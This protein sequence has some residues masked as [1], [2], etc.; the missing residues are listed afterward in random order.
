MGMG[1]KKGLF[2]SVLGLLLLSGMTFAANI[3]N[4]KQ[5][6]ILMAARSAD[7]SEYCY[8][9]GV[10][11]EDKPALDPR[12]ASLR[13]AKCRLGSVM[14]MGHRIAFMCT[15]N[16]ADYISSQ[17]LSHMNRAWIGIK[18]FPASPEAGRALIQSNIA[19]GV[20]YG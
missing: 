3:P 15:A 5:I 9:N 18:M 16:F 2:C 10:C 4:G 1:L 17:P 14:F 13:V 7:I 8:V 19:Y 12:F 11:V 20:Q 6:E